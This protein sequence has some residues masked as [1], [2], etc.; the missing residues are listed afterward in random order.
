MTGRVTED[1]NLWDDFAKYDPLWAILSDP[2]KAGRRWDLRRFLETGRRE[3]SLLFYQLRALGLAVERRAALDFG[4]GVGRLSQ[5]LASH[6]ERVVGV[7]VSAEMI[8]LANVINQY[9]DRVRYVCNVRDDL[10]IFSPSEFSFI[11][12]NV[13]LQHIVPER[14]LLYLGEMLRVL[15]PGGLLVFQLP[16]HLRPESEQRLVSTP[17]P[18]A[19]Y[20]ASVRIESDLPP[21]VMPGTAISLV[22]SV[23]NKSSLPW[24]QSESGPL[25]LGNHWL[26][27]AH[28][29][30]IQDDGRASLPV[31]IVPG[32]QCHVTLEVTAPADPGEYVLECDAVHEGISWFADKGSEAC[33]TRITVAGRSELEPFRQESVPASEDIALSLS[34]D[35]SLVSPGPLPMHGIPFGIVEDTI[36]AHGGTLVQ[37][38][39]DERCGKEWVGYRYIVGKAVDRRASVSRTV[40]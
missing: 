21:R 38:E 3:I 26:S 20:A 5:P 28:V 31:E 18:A 6:F 33:R 35:P 8:R 12:S 7:D 15:A 14:V 11:Y 16:S 29:M 17:M 9:P 2:T 36:A 13:V 27:P 1:Q 30:L 4:C 40:G 19:A 34:D 32:Q 37:R 25:R 24:R 22:A 10:A 23:T 39:P